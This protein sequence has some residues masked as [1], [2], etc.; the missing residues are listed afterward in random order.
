[1][2]KKNVSSYQQVS[3]ILPAFN[4]EK[5]I[6]ETVKDI[7][8]NFPTSTIFVIDNSSTDKTA[9]IARNM[10]AVVIL[11]SRRGKGFAVQRGFD[12]VLTTDVNV[13]VLLDADFTYGT[14][15]VSGAIKSVIYDGVDMVVG[16]RIP[17]VRSGTDFSEQHF[18]F[19]H[20]FGNKF[21]TWM[22]RILLPAGIEDVL[23]GWRVM[24]RPFV[25]SFP[26]GSK[27]FEIEAQLNSHAFNLN[28]MVTNVNI[29]YYARPDGSQSKLNTY[30]D[31]T[32]ILRTTL[33]NFRND[34]P[35]VAFSSLSVPWLLATAVLFY[36]P[37]KTY[38]ETGLVPYLPRLVA[39]VGTFLIACLLWISGV[40]LE[41]I[42]DIKVQITR[43]KYHESRSAA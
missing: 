7:Q 40:L 1:M 26:G 17:Q 16:T 13:I 2:S 41:R 38:I 22:A 34:R 29:D 27:G 19:G 6:A 28:A 3:F 14:N 18:R 4:E 24:S 9:E 25:K 39:G 10:G 35:F 43:A 20:K 31:G 32:R 36:L 33:R 21:F 23:S 12:H 11:E 8:L 15:Q 42:K 5:T 37:F 30:R